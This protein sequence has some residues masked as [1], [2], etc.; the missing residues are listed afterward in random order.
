[1][2]GVMN[3]SIGPERNGQI[4]WR[5]HPGDSWNNTY[6]DIN[7]KHGDGD[8]N[9]IVDIAD[10]NINKQNSLLINRYYDSAS[11]YPQGPEISLTSNPEFDEQ[12]RIK[13]LNVKV[14]KDIHNAL[15]V[16]FELEFDTTLF[17]IKFPF[18]Q[19]H[20]DTSKLYYSEDLNGTNLRYAYVNKHN[21]TITIDSGARFFL[22]SN[23]NIT[24]KEGMQVPDSTIVRLRNLIARDAEG[25]DLHIGSEPLVVYKANIVGTIDP[26]KAKT[27]VYPNPTIGFI[28]IET[29]I[30]SE[31]QLFSLQGQKIRHLSTNELES[32]VDVSA[33]PP[34]MFILR[35][36]ATGE[37]IKVIV[38]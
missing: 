34:G 3:G 20:F 36:Q 5:G 32:P 4:S 8:G 15:G 18:L 21:T 28:Q 31:A 9:G 25:N 37:S 14:N 33:L 17:Y 11:T 38:Q 26:S 30:E 10:I 24:L 1:M 27:I 6:V 2:W 22:G 29:A 16:A 7:A 23:N 19:S 35:I 13:G 12:G